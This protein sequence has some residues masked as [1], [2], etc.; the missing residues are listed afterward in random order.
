MILSSRNPVA[1][2]YN[3][4]HPEVM[5]SGSFMKIDTNLLQDPWI[6][7]HAISDPQSCAVTTQTSTAQCLRQINCSMFTT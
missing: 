2:Y 4:E 1:L 3:Y 6:R 7:T 5:T